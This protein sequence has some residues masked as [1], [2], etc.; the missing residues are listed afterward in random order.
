M[1]QQVFQQYFHGKGQAGHI[2]QPGFAR[3]G[4]GEIIIILAAHVQRS[5]GI[6]V[7]SG[8]GDFSLGGG[9]FSGW[10][11]GRWPI[12][13]Y[14]RP[15][16]CAFSPLK[17]KLFARIWGQITQKERRRVKPRHFPLCDTFGSHS[18]VL[19][20]I[21]EDGQSEVPPSPLSPARRPL[22][23]FTTEVIIAV[24]TTSKTGFF[25]T[26]SFF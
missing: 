5:Q 7:G 15:Y 14:E 11:A 24:L 17:S 23:N 21:K 26:R 3:R 8:H 19:I 2:T 6:N 9:A 4:D 13:L 10:A 18:G 16:I 20:I 25:E 1:A 12:G 22:S